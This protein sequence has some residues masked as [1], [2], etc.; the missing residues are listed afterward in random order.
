MK[1]TPKNSPENISRK[2]ALKKIGSVG[3]YAA[4]T[5]LGTYT[6]LSP[7]KAQAASPEAPG[8]GGF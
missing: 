2:E 1:N 7:Q 6:L 8:S 3:K 5:A 4:F